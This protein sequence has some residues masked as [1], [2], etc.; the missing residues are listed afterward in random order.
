MKRQVMS[1]ISLTVENRELLIWCKTSVLRILSPAL[2]VSTKKLPYYI[3]TIVSDLNICR[4]L[5]FEVFRERNQEF[6]RNIINI[7]H[8]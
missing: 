6:H 8:I 5:I 3:R 4:K 2:L 1:R 7:N